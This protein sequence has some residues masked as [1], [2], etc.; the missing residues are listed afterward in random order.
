MVLFIILLHK[1]Q[2]EENGRR[3]SLGQS[4]YILAMEPLH[5]LPAL[6]GGFSIDL[7]FSSPEPDGAMKHRCRIS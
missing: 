3:E 6:L 1:P 5:S 2:K 7:A 4:L